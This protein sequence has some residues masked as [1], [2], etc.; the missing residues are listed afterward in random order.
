MLW[1]FL[2][3]TVVSTLLAVPAWAPL[4]REPFSVIS[5]LLGW[6]VAE[7]PVHAAV[8]VLAG[9]VVLGGAAHPRHA[10]WWLAAALGL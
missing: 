1:A 10:V 3:F 5:F 9:T 8:V 6:V 4:R 2:A 7:V